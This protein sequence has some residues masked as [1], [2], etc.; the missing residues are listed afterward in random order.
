MPGRG[1]VPSGDDMVQSRR[2]DNLTR[3]R[4][5]IRKCS[6]QKAHLRHC[7][8]NVTE[9]V[10]RSEDGIREKF[11]VWAKGR[12]CRGAVLNWRQETIGSRTCLPTATNLDRDSAHVTFFLLFDTSGTNLT[13]LARDWIADVDDMSSHL[14]NS[15]HTYGCRHCRAAATTFVSAVLCNSASFLS[16]KSTPCHRFIVSSKVRLHFQSSTNALNARQNIS[17][18]FPPGTPPF[19]TIDNVEPP[20]VL[21]L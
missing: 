15:I 19:E 6:F 12:V 4:V 2:S 1:D 9:P 13:F 16:E 14:H 7:E 18:H 10:E 21:V 5:E 3:R 20:C 17:T 11:Q 8:V